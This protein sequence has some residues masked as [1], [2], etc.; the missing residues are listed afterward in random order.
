[1]RAGSFGVEVKVVSRTKLSVAVVGSQSPDRNLILSALL[2]DSIQRHGWSERIDVVSVGFGQGAGPSD[3]AALTAL[4]LVG[5][6]PAC[7][8]LDSDADLLEDSDAVVVATGEDADLVVTWPE[9]EAKQVF[10][11]VDYLGDEGWAIADPSAALD[12]YFAQVK[13]SLPHLLRAL[14]AR[15]N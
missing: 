11:L 13:E 12:D 7:P 10:A 14:I 5:V 2:L 6:E 9:L 3:Q 4:G 15:P 8:D 1:M